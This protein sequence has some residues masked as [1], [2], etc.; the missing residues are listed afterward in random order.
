MSIYNVVYQGEIYEALKISP[1]Y[2]AV[3]DESAKFQILNGGRE[4]FIE[5]L[6]Q[7][8]VYLRDEK[9][10]GYSDYNPKLGRT[11]FLSPFLHDMVAGVK[12]DDKVLFSFHPYSFFQ[13]TLN[14]L[15]GLPSVDGYLPEYSTVEKL[16]QQTQDYFGSLLPKTPKWTDIMGFKWE[17]MPGYPDMA[18]DN[19]FPE[20]KT[21]TRTPM[22][23]VD[24][25]EREWEDMFGYDAAT[26]KWRDIVKKQEQDP[27]K[28]MLPVAL[29]ALL[30]VLISANQ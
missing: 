28:N 29:G 24:P 16:K 1:G 17:E 3:D 22:E 19:M 7:A 27:K 15:P 20:Q 23:S 10:S 4:L 14:Y 2:S 18:S 5:Q 8:P 30:F 25:S 26:P 13:R 12:T 9:G 6:D 11:L 21:Q